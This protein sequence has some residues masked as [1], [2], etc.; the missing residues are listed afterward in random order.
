MFRII[1]VLVA[2]IAVAAATV[3]VYSHVTSSL[4]AGVN[5]R[6]EADV[7]RAQKE[8]LRAARLDG[9]D[10]ANQAAAFAREDELV[11][12]FSKPE[13]PAK[14]HPEL[15]TRDQAAFV[16]VEVRKA[17]LEKKDE[18][19]GEEPAKVGILGIVDA[20]G[21]LLARDLQPEWRHLDDLRKDFPSLSVALGGQPNKDLWNLDGGMYRVGAA[22]IR[23][24]QGNVLGAVFVGYVQSSRD[25]V[26]LREIL[27]TEVAFFMD[28][29][30]HASSFQRQNETSSSETA[31]EK[32]LAGQLFDGL[33]LAE[34]TVTSRQAT[35]VLKVKIGNENWI[36]A[37]APIPGN[38]TPSKSGFVVLQ[39]LNREKVDVAPIGRAVL[40]LGLAAI[41][42]LGGA[43]FVVS[44]RFIVGLDRMYNGASEVINGNRDFV[45][46][47]PSADFEGLANG[48]N[49][50]LARL[51]GR[52]DPDDEEAAEEARES[53][54]LRQQQ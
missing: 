31:E 30:I 1:V 32:A 47:S 36:A 17:R 14:D 22:P 6:V 29:K 2:G 8:L 37:A 41:L 52:P 53:R 11:Q 16:A 54:D 23:G 10:L 42:L 12:I 35:S 26:A 9:F 39:S 25:A 40:G 15:K 7:V 44:R 5:Q 21:R 4:E 50:M 33:K 28:G 46:E 20:D 51:L 13:A 19:R 38:A 45:F 48:L 18:T 24:P 43:V 27:G 34:Q 3:G 49:V